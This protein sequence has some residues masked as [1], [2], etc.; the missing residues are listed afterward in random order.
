[1]VSP[2]ERSAAI[3]DIYPTIAEHMRFDMPEEVAAQLEGQSLLWK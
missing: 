2:A 1:M 3:V